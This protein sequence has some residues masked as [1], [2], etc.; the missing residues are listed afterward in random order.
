VFPTVDAPRSVTRI[1]RLL[2][3][4]ASPRLWPVAAVVAWV[5]LAAVVAFSLAGA[6][7]GGASN[8]GWAA[9]RAEIRKLPESVHHH[10]RFRAIRGRVTNEDGK[11]VAGALVRCVRVESLVEVAKGAPPDSSG[12]KLPIEA[13]LRTG[14]DGSYDFPHLPVGARTLFYSAPGRDLAPAI[15]DLIVVQDG[16]GAQLNVTLARPKRLHVEL[17]WSFVVPAV[18]FHLIPHRWWPEMVTVPV[19]RG[20]TSVEFRG[21]GGPFRKGLIAVS[22][23]GVSSPL[24]VV[25]RYDLDRGGKI[26]IVRPGQPA[27][28]YD[29]AEAAGFQAWNAAWGS[30]EQQFYAAITPIA[31]YW[32]GVANEISPTS[33]A[34]VFLPTL[35][36]SLH[37]GTVRGFGLHPLLPVLVESRSG[38]SALTWTSEASEFEL[39]GLPQGPYRARALD[40]FGRVTFARGGYAQRNRTNNEASRQL[41]KL[42]LDEP[43]SRE[44]MGFVRW[45]S[46]IPAAKAEV[47]MQHAR[48]FRRYLRRVEADEN[49]FFQFAG[50]PGG[51][52]YFIF[53]VPPRDGT[54]MR[55]FEYFGVAPFQREVWR[56]LTLHPHRVTGT[57][58]E[59]ARIARGATPRDGG[60]LSG[61]VDTGVFQ[62]VSIRGKSERIVWTFRAG[63]SGMFT[64]SNVPHGCYRVQVRH[65]GG[66]DPVPSQP[67]EVGDGQPEIGVRWP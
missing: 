15:K 5:P 50:V 66:G 51:A 19:A 6:N 35:Y 67:F 26:F 9:H 46:G 44:V 10:D 30:A 31:L 18:R 37:R 42:E 39:G 12:W 38:G 20:A 64:V 32:Q 11:P 54:A 60:G 21:L 40:L 17:G 4:L 34:A 63:R 56:D 49:G 7:S 28:R 61:V 29:V 62:L 57:V 14:E 45:E 58:P 43:E 25:G 13:E 8:A 23:P 33:I 1:G 53:A 41:R 52:A 27:S 48:S 24:R 2:S 65:P 22:G 36:K 47:Y 3:R 16:L 59:L 55:G